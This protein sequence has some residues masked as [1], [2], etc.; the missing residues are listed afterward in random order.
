M[1]ACSSLLISSYLV[2]NFF[3]LCGF[4]IK[5][6]NIKTAKV[7]IKTKEEELYDE[8]LNQ[9]MYN[10]EV[11]AYFQLLSKANC[12]TSQDILHAYTNR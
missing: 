12:D 7:L 2:R 4:P 9:Y 11:F 6:S 10:S 5:K 3:L 1:K 8:N